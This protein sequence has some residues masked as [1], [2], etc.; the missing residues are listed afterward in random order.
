MKLTE[1]IS[2]MKSIMGV[3][4][5]N[6]LTE[7]L[8]NVEDD[9]DMLF[10]TYFKDLL[11]TLLTTRFLPKRMIETIHTDTR[12]LKNDLCVKAHTLNPCKI[13][14]NPYPDGYGVSNF[15]GTLTHS[16]GISFGASALT[17][18]DEHNGSLDACL[19]DLPDNQKERFLTEFTDYRVKG[20]IH[21]ELAHWLDDT[22]NNNHITKTLARNKNI[23]VAELG[24]EFKYID[25][26]YLEIQAQIHNIKQM[27]NAH[28]AQWDQLTFEDML[29]LTPALPFI[30]RLPEHLKIAWLKNIKKRMNR[31]G[32]LGANMR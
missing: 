32:L 16:I 6:L 22:F 25:S 14:I 13:I 3:N 26:H 2:K 28:K 5:N 4:E 18:L 12:I 8:T 10:N 31:E 9:V 20:S 23:P 1:Q 11:N 19:R 29:K 21:H 30:K 15:Y 17:Y 24:D 7:K 27:Y